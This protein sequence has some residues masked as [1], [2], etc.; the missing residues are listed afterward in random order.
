MF[1]LRKNLTNILLKQKKMI[2]KVISMLRWKSQ[3]SDVEMFKKT[4]FCGG[5]LGFL[6]AISQS[7][8]TKFGTHI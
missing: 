6:V 1:H 8:L 7:I 3:R 4:K 5:H 2:Y